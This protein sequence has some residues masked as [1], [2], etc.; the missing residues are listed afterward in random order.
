MNGCELLH[1]TYW[2]GAMCTDGR[3]FVNQD[4]NK[5]CGLRDDAILIE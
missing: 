5:V 4:K 3:K 1:C 2:N